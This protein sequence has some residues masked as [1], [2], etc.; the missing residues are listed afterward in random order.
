MSWRKYVVDF[1]QMGREKTVARL[2]GV[3]LYS[4]FIRIVLILLA[5]QMMTGWAPRKSIVRHS[6]SMGE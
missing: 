3:F 6:R 2:S 5:E 4:L 1:L